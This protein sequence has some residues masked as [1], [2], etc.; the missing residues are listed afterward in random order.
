MA[1][2]DNSKNSNAVSCFL[3]EKK[4]PGIT[5]GITDKKMGQA[6]A[7]TADVILENC[8]VPSNALLGEEEGTGF[9]TAMKVLDKGR[10]H[11]SAICVGLAT[12]LIDECI[13]YALSRKQFGKPIAEFQLIQAMIADSQTEMLA[14]KSMV[15]EGARKRDAGENTTLEASCAK[16][17]S[18]ESL[19]KIAD[20]AVQ[21]YGGSGYMSEYPIE[22]FY[23]DS[24]LFRI[25]EVIQISFGRR[26]FI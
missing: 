24:R 18:S 17:F 9:H 20:R 19:G 8:V 3:V 23:R 10:I 21:I 16:L 14:A 6:G 22:R 11:I 1:K 12:R 2:T 25:Y 13:S 26:I 7:L 5:I 4:F 15:L